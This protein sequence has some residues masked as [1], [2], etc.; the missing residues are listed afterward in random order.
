MSL[1]SEQIVWFYRRQVKLLEGG[2]RNQEKKSRESAA[3][4]MV[5]L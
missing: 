3:Q 1:W 4:I 5:L 2:A